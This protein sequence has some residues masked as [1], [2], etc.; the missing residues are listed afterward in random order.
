[1]CD[2]LLFVVEIALQNFV[3][4][5]DNCLVAYEWDYLFPLLELEESIPKISY[6]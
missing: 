1:M 4:D 3:Q 5:L 6:C 2:K